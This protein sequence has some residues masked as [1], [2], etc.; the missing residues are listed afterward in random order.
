MWA[1]V[2]SLI[3]S[4]QSWVV[5]RRFPLPVEGKYRVRGEQMDGVM[6]TG[7]DDNNNNNGHNSWFIKLF[8]KFPSTTHSSLGRDNEPCWTSVQSFTMPQPTIVYMHVPRT[9]LFT[10]VYCKDLT[11]F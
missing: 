6:D 3:L 11:D 1:T 2:P 4:S 10:S 9:T 8:L 7:Y 5:S